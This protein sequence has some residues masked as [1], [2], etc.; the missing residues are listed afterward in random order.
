[1]SGRNPLEEHFSFGGIDIEVNPTTPRCQAFVEGDEAIHVFGYGGAILYV[2]PSART[3]RT[4][5]VFPIQKYN[6]V[7]E[8]EEESS[9]D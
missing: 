1:M 9:Y 3:A 6:K 2:V 5:Y 8:Q 7:Q 4:V